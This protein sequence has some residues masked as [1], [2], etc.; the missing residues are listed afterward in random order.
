LDRIYE[1]FPVLKERASQKGGSLS[2]GEQ[3]MLAFGRAMMAR[4]K[5]LMLDE[6]SL[7]L[8]PRMVEHLYEAISKIKSS[9]TI[10]LVE[11]SIHLALEVADRGY[12]LRE[13]RIVGNGTSAELSA[14][15]LLH[16]AYLGNDSIM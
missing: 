15:S 2:G 8:S 13:G 6:P 1:L 16:S 12:L 7:G 4:P 14:G 10:L 3:Q 11:Q 9:V 5:L